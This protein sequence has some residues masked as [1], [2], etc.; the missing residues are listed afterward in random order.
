MGLVLEAMSQALHERG[1]S[2]MDSLQSASTAMSIC[3]LLF[4]F[5]RCAY[6]YICSSEACSR[7]VSLDCRS[8]FK[9]A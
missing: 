9:V 2:P 3:S 7:Y 6:V 5:G 8:V 4:P 1:A